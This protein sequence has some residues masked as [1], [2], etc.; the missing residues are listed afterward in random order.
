MMSLRVKLSRLALAAAL[1]APGLLAGCGSESDTPEAQ[2]ATQATGIKPASETHKTVETTRDVIVEK[3]TKVKDATTGEILSDKKES[4][5]VKITEEKE[6]KT[7]VKVD[8]G[9]T[10]TTGAPKK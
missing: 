4:T 3:E 6:V 9:D 10:K 7:D 1:S 2:T 5:P 8:V